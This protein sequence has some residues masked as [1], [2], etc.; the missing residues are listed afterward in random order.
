MTCHSLYLPRANLPGFAAC[1]FYHSAKND[2]RACMYPC[3]PLSPPAAPCFLLLLSAALCC[4]LLPCAALGHPCY[5]L[6]SLLSSPVRVPTDL[7]IIIFS[8]DFSM[9]F[10]CLFHDHFLIFHDHLSLIFHLQHFA[11]NMQTF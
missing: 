6:P 2:W 4:P 5:P 7:T 9:T 11:E 1:Q 10:P 3:H 8:H